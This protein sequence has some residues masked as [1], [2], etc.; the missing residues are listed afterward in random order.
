MRTV[1]SRGWGYRRGT[2]IELDQDRDRGEKLGPSAPSGG[3]LSGVDV[4]QALY[5][6]LVASVRDYAIFMLDPAGR[7]TTWNLGAQR[8]K[9]YAAHEVIGT[10]FSRF[11][12][13]EDVESGK[14]EMELALAAEQGRFED[15]GWRVRKDGT[16]FWANVVITA[17]RDAEGTLL[18]F[19]KVT[20]DLTEHRRAEEERIHLAS[21]QRARA[22]A[23]AS[24]RAKDNFLAHVSHEL[25]TPLNA[26]LG[27]AKLLNGGLDEARGRQATTTIERNAVAM[28]Q[29]IDDLLD[30]S[31]IISGRMRLEAEPVDLALVIDR[32]M[33]AVRLNAES[34]GV[35]VRADVEADVPMITGD[36]IRLQQVVWNL[37]SNA[38]KF[39]PPGGDIRVKLRRSGRSAELS[40]RDTGRGI[41]PANAARVF[42]PFWQEEGKPVAGSR[43]LGLGLSI[44]KNLVELHGGSIDVWSEGRDRGTTFTCTFPLASA[45][46]DPATLR[47]GKHLVAS[48]PRLVGARVLV[49]EDEADTRSLVRAVLEDA[50]C[51]VTEAANVA[52]AV[53][54]LEDEAALDAL[55]SDIGLPDGDGYHLIR[56]LRSRPP[57]RGGNLPAAAITAYARA[58]DRVK[59]LEA[60]FTIHLAKPIEPN[61]LKLVVSALVA[62]RR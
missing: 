33:D 12:P 19:G 5:R 60:G 26:I 38:V 10:H 23:D 51:I 6:L 17:L 57:E 31:R 11:Y 59:A 4:D 56:E 18:G 49:V 1:V 14:C 46:P 44:S 61:E 21:E 36:P 24:N 55:V 39:T 45:A 25:R 22:A 9:Q 58:E 29:L 8:I 40:V 3:S 47:T 34:R 2:L 62:Q 42:E 43:G 37:L 7:V 13:A 16:R 32:G 48:L 41:E 52:E 28:V 50:G 15:E 27:W 20:R 54:R 30:V 35:K 53:Q